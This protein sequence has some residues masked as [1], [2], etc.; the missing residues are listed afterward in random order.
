MA[1]ANNILMGAASIELN[2]TDIGFTQGGTTV[3][4]AIESVEVPADQQAAIVRKGVSMRRM[5]VTFGVLEIS[6][7]FM[8]VAYSLPSSQVVGGTQLTLGYADSCWVP[9]H[10][11]T[12]VGPAPGCGTRTWTFPNCNVLTDTEYAM[13]RENASVLET[14]FEVISDANGNFGTVVDIV[15]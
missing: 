12:L 15:A 9:S 5:Y 13:T 4:S 10:S 1:D 11:L 8:A 2:G 3:R 14:E 7:D 6:L